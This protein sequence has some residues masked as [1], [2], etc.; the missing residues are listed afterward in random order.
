MIWPLPVVIGSCIVGAESIFP[1][2]TIANL[3]PTFSD[4]NFAKA[5]APIELNVVV[6][7]GRPFWSYATR[8][9]VKFSPLTAILFL[10]TTLPTISESI[11]IF[12][13]CIA[14]SSTIWNVILA[15]L[16]ISSFTLSG[17]S[18]P[19]SCTIILFSPCFWIDGSL[20]PKESTRRRTISIELF[21]ISVF[22][23]WIAASE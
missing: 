14:S 6:T 4:V 11:G 10:I 21:K 17:L 7:A 20:F 19:G 16:P 1:S 3:F 18:A 8:E 23:F 13:V 12:P 9:S 5:L 15:V 2:R 22:I